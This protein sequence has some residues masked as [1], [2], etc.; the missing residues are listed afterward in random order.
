MNF[1][2]KDTHR[3]KMKEYTND[4]ENI[5]KLEKCGKLSGLEEI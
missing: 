2:F 3:L 4:N 5:P 1:K